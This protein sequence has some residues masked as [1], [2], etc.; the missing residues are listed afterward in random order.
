MKN[1]IFQASVSTQIGKKVTSQDNFQKVMGEFAKDLENIIENDEALKTF[2]EAQNSFH[3]VVTR[4]LLNGLKHVASSNRYDGYFENCSMVELDALSMKDYLNG[5]E[6]STNDPESKKLLNTLEDKIA[7]TMKANYNTYN[8]SRGIAVTTHE[9]QKTLE[10]MLKL[11]KDLQ[12][13]MQEKKEKEIPDLTKLIAEMEE[14]H[15]ALFN[16][17]GASH[18]QGLFTDDGFDR[19]HGYTSLSESQKELFRQFPD[20]VKNW[21]NY[22]DK[23][24]WEHRS[25]NDLK[26]PLENMIEKSKEI[27]GL[28]DTIKNVDYQTMESKQNLRFTAKFTA[29]ELEPFKH[30]FKDLNPKE[31]EIKKS[32]PVK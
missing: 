4:L 15:K 25:N 12:E 14:M 2:Y 28:L 26:Q 11:A 1:T 3:A 16:L 32:R 8:L 5:L 27:S 20:K 22:L 31:D 10:E 17:T 6:S 21:R 30:R 23:I 13:E 9:A 18:G 29:N 19:R 24:S 7:R